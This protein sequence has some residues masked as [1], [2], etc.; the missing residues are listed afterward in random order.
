MVE[1]G[2]SGLAIFEDHVEVETGA[3]MVRARSIFGV[4][5]AVLVTQGIHVR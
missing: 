2:V 3:P 1:D 4:R 5:D